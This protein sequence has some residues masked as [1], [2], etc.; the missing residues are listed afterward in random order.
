MGRAL[1]RGFTSSISDL[2]AVKNSPSAFGAKHRNSITVFPTPSIV[3]SLP[4]RKHKNADGINFSSFWMYEREGSGRVRKIKKIGTST[5]LN[6]QRASSSE[7]LSAVAMS[8]RTRVSQ[9][10]FARQGRGCG[11]P[12]AAYSGSP[13]SSRFFGVM[14]AGIVWVQTRYPRCSSRTARITSTASDRS[15]HPDSDPESFAA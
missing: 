3:P 8:A 2:Y 13:R 10:D 5:C 4:I 11:S 14:A 7:P 15:S 9:K 12:P 1:L 6:T